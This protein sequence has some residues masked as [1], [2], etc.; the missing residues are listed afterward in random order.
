MLPH[1]AH[2]GA[3]ARGVPPTKGREGL[4]HSGAPEV[5][6]SR[7]PALP[8]AASPPGAR[9][10]RA[11]PGNKVSTLLLPPAAPVNA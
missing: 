6:I 8:G 7:S 2:E 11:E 4:G 10:S 5:F 9:S 1:R 3:S